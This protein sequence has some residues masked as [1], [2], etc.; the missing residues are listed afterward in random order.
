MTKESCQLCGCTVAAVK[1]CT[2]RRKA[3]EKNV[4]ENTHMFPELVRKERRTPMGLSSPRLKGY[5]GS[6]WVN[7]SPVDIR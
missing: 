4:E 6:A 1:K 5:P 7:F 3:R 2:R